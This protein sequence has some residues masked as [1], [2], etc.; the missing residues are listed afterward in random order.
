MIYDI[1]SILYLFFQQVFVLDN[2]LREST[3]AQP[4]G[5]TLANKIKILEQ[6]EACS[7]TD[8]IVAAFG[9]DRRVDDA[10]CEN[11]HE[12]IP[13]TSSIRHSYAFTEIWE[14]FLPDKDVQYGN[15]YIPTGLKKMKQ[16]GIQNAII[17]VDLDASYVDWDGK[18][19]V[20]KSIDVLQ[21]LLEWTQKNLDCPKGE[22]RRN[23]VNL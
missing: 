10:F 15:D 18:V 4:A 23:M 13:S 21:F 8:V 12:Y 22:N 5:H 14:T 7:F 11:L 3:V 16:Y 9:N 19:T 20:S 1:L 2:S 6:I 17:E